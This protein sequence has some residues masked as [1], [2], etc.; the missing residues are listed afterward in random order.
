MRLTRMIMSERLRSFV[1]TA[2]LDEY[3]FER[4]D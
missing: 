2:L 4:L 3:G 1:P